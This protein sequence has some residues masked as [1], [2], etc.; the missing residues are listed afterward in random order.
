MAEKAFKNFSYLTIG[1]VTSS[2]M[3]AIF[4]LIFAALLEPTDYGELGYLIALAGTFSALS[5]F[6]LTQS[7]MVYRAKLEIQLS[8]QVTLLAIIT[9]SVASIILIFI[10]VFSA[11]LCLTASLFMLYQSNILGERRYKWFFKNSVLRNIL[12]FLTCFP[13]YFVLDIPGI[14]LGLAFS[15]IVSSIWLIKYVDLKEKSLRLIKNNYKILINNFGVDIS[16]NLGVIIDRLLVATVFGFAFAGLYI[17]NM[18]I[19]LV[20]QL[21]PGIL[22][23]FLISEEASGKKHPKIN[24]LVV[25]ISILAALAVIIFSP[26]IIEQLFP[27]YSDGIPGLQILVISIIPTSISLIMTAKMQAQ[28]SA[29]VGYSAIV[30]IGS[31]LILLVLLGNEYGLIGVSLAVLTSAILNTIFLFFLYRITTRKS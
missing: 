20:L 26:T 9:T 5:R 2:A 1:N 4:F 11:F 8:N 14:L 3:T 6:G 12:T 19:L 22:Y 10:N 31:L 30:N 25:L 15:N 21:L 24:Y 17:F 18:H 7:V 27:N 16:F 23:V 28:K 13:L 29:R